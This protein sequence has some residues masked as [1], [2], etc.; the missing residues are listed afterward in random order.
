MFQFDHGL[1]TLTEVDADGFIGVQVD[2]PGEKKG[3]VA[4]GEMGFPFGMFARP[5]DP[6]LDADGEPD[7]A[8]SAACLYGYY[9]DRLHCWPQTDPRFMAKL[10]RV[11]KGGN[12]LYGGKKEQPTFVHIDGDSG[13]IDV[14]VPYAFDGNGVAQKSMTMT[15]DMRASGTETIALV[16]GDGM[17]VTMIAGGK[18]SVTVKN[19]AGDAYVEVNDDGVIANGNTKLIGAIVA[20]SQLAP[21][22]P[23]A[24]APPLLA[25]TTALEAAIAT[26]LATIPTVGAA[27]AAAFTTAMTAA[28]AGKALA[29]ALFVKG[30]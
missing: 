26:A 19:K 1:V 24:L 27:T 3:G 30:N 12:V 17:A 18:H 21:Y 10:P 13:S 15:F 7:P 4:S 25:Y 6:E 14:Y 28:A 11:K 20:G 23:L 5:H 8:K 16:H 2:V 22:Q 29:T 9:G